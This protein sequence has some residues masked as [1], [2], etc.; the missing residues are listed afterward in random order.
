MHLISHKTLVFHA[1]DRAHY[2]KIDAD[3]RVCHLQC[4]PSERFDQRSEMFGGK[5]CK[6]LSNAN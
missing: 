1:L 3:K 5:V 2:W 6:G 4:K